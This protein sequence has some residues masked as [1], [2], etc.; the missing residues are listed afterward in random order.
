MK[1]LV[2][3]GEIFFEKQRFTRN[4]EQNLSW[5]LLHHIKNTYFWFCVAITPSKKN[6]I[7]K[8]NFLSLSKFWKFEFFFDFENFLIWIWKPLAFLKDARTKYQ[9][10]EKKYYELDRRRN[11][12]REGRCVIFVKFSICSCNNP[13]RKTCWKKQYRILKTVSFY[14]QNLRASKKCQKK[15]KKILWAD[16]LRNRG[17]EVRNRGREV[18]SG[19]KFSIYS[20]NKTQK[21][22]LVINRNVWPWRFLD[23]S[24]NLRAS[25]KSQKKKNLWI[26]A[27][28]REKR[29]GERFSSFSWNFQ[30]IL[31][32]KKKQEEKLIESL[33]IFFGARSKRRTR[34]IVKT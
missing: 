31:I 27:Y 2:C 29:E 23:F 17:R 9:K 24:Q 34:K 10:K 12:E 6:F 33:I 5:H 22:Y 25:K 1:I 13:R 15:E 3:N 20:Y 8:R 30:S 16:V 11:R 28:L 14:A 7:F 18:S 4:R 32:T 21:N 26:L 19:M